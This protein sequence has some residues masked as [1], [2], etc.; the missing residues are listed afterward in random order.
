MAGT[1]DGAVKMAAGKLGVSVDE[2]RKRKAA[3]DRWCWSCKMW[4]LAAQ[5]PQN[6]GYPGGVSGKCLQ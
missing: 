5:F 6:S 3:G 1:K 4:K 2:Y